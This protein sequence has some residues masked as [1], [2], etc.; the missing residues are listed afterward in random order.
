MRTTPLLLAATCAY[1][2]AGLAPGG[3]AQAACAPNNNSPQCASFVVISSEEHTIVD[4]RQKRASS[5]TYLYR[6]C[7]SYGTFDVRS[8]DTDLALGPGDCIDLDVAGGQT[9]KVVGRG[10]IA[11]GEYLLLNGGK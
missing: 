4:I 3:T 1:A 9:I 8:E 5:T 11:S 10:D 6:V 2:V 7:A